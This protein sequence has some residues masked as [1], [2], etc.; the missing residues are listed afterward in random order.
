MFVSLIIE[1]IFNDIQVGIIDNK[2]AHPPASA[3][4]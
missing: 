2:R 4:E 1:H 3:G